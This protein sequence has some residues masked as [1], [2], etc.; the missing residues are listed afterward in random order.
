[1]TVQVG[2]VGLGGI[3]RMHANQLAEHAA[4]WG[5]EL[6]G[7][8]DVA[9][10]ARERFA[11]RHDCATFAEPG[12][13]YDRCDAVLIA[14]PNRYHEEYA[15]GALRA[16]LDVLVEK[17]LAHSLESAEAIAAAA[18]A[19]DGFCMVGFQ[20]RFAPPATV[21]DGYR[22]RG[23]LGE[24]YHVEARYLRRRGV[25]GLG[26][27]FTD[28]ELAGGGALVDVGVHVLDLGLHQLGFPPV[29]EVTGTARSQFGGREDYTYL[30]MWGEDG[31]GA[32]TVEDSVSGFVRC[33][34]DR[35]LSLEVAWAANRPPAAEVI[36]WGTAGGARLGLHGGGLTLYESASHGRDHHATTEIETG[37]EAAHAEEKRR[38][39]AGVR[40]GEAPALNTVDQGLTV[41]RVVSALYRSSDSGGA[42][43]LD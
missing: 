4:E 32:F 10:E 43:R 38:F 37:E 9:A 20:S 30:R 23:R 17:P 33:R 15:T 5:C 29:T 22:D 13:L 42:M 3:G 25:P 18:S 34:G 16:G 7:G 39:L 21:L 41:Q 26:S 2:I 24:V 27:W 28:D 40:T 6:V 1:M 12:P 35:T 11:D 8:V 14:T 19:A 36:V 31:A